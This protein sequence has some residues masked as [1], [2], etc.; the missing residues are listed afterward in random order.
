MKNTK[1]FILPLLL[2]FVG[3]GCPPDT[4][5]DEQIEYEDVH[6][7]IEE[8]DQDYRVRGS[9]NVIAEKSTC[10]DYTGSYWDSPDVKELNCDGVGVY[11]DNTCPY[12]NLGGCQATPGTMFETIVWHYGHGGQPFDQETASYAA[13][14]CNALATAQWV[15][16][17]QVFLSPET[18]Q[19]E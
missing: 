4:P 12:T 17:D 2:V 16:P 19:E 6:E 3:A 10:V 5:E 7:L 1:Y 15:T 13:A 9:C 11:S 18:T 14:A 8:I